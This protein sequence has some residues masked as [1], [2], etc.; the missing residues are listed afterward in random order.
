MHFSPMLNYK[1]WKKRAKT[2]QSRRKNKAPLGFQNVGN[3][4]TLPKYSQI[5]DLR[6]EIQ[7]FGFFLSMHVKA[8][9]N[10]PH[11]NASP[12]FSFIA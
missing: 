10:G 6:N 9:C 8:L 1:N 2:A 11:N 3:D 12:D 4:F 7:I 5:L